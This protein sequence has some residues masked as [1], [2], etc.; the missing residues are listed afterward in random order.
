MNI[1]FNVDQILQMSE[2]IEQ[3]NA[4][5]YQSAAEQAEASENKAFLEKMAAFELRHESYFARLRS[6]LSRAE[7]EQRTFDPDN[8]SMQYCQNH[9]DIQQLFDDEIDY[10]DIRTVLK[11]AIQHE[12]DSIVFYLGMRDYVP[13]RLGR[14]KV[15][16][17]IQEEMSHIN[18]LTQQLNQL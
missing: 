16:E 6:E 12:K 11:T 13:E 14:S 3:N 5:F 15:D 1:E 10:S 8:Q 18:I 2:R 4:R 17:I 7:K 9:A